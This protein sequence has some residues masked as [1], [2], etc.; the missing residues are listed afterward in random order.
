MFFLPR[1]PALIWRIRAVLAREMAADLS[2]TGCY[3]SASDGHWVFPDW[4]DE[5]RARAQAMVIFVSHA[6]EEEQ[7]AMFADADAAG[8]D[9]AV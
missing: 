8:A 7:A 3:R 5:D 4:A 9:S 6:T 1:W 2:R